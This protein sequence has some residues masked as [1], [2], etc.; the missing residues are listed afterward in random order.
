[1]FL[2]VNIRKTCFGHIWPSSGFISINIK[3]ILIYIKP[4][5]G[6]IWPKHVVF[7]LNLKNILLLYFIQ[8]VFLTTL[9]PI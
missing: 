2:I 1:M 7:I 8:V 3:L 4:G 5:D 9:P 6:H